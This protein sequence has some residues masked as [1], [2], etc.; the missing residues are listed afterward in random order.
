V[1]VDGKLYAVNL[2]KLS[3]EQ[4]IQP[5]TYLRR[6]LLHGCCGTS[7]FKRRLQRWRLR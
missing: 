2:R 6:A 5:D 4:I 3:K 7:V 1:N